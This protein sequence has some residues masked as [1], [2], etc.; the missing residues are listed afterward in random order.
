MEIDKLLTDFSD[1]NIYDFIEKNETPFYLFSEKIIQKQYQE[2]VRLFKTYWKGKWEIAY[3]LKNNPLPNIFQLT[4]KLGS[5]FEVTNINEMKLLRRY[6]ITGDLII[7]TNLIK[8]YSTL[9]YALNNDI[10]LFAI[11]SESDLERIE[12]IAKNLNKKVQV[13]LRINPL[14]EFDDI[15]FSCSGK[16]SKIG[17]PITLEEENLPN[18]RLGIIL[19]RITNSVFLK[20]KGIHMHL[21]SQITSEENYRLALIK[22][23]KLINLLNEKGI[24]PG[25]LDFGGGIPISYTNEDVPTAESLLKIAFSELKDIEDNIKLIIEPG[26][27]ISGPSGI[28]ISTIEIIK[29]NFLGNLILGLDF[30]FYNLLLDCIT[31]NWEFPVM[32]LQRNVNEEELLEYY[33]I[34]LTNDTLDTL[35]SD[36]KYTKF[37]LPK[38][39]EGEK[40]AFLQAGAYTIPFNNHYCLDSLPKIFWEDMNGKITLIRKTIQPKLLVDPDVRN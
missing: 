2:L 7:Y 10:S 40:I 28:L 5:Y 9:E 24:N 20:F 18:S 29:E 1:I 22:I 31:S 30:S 17:I 13:L 16:L 25:I 11:D 39:K 32:T 37:N 23:R 38:L 21:G 19:R 14:I 8:P 26:R 36:N 4:K 6:G 15:V 33:I 3:S 12:R 27:Y 34:G 35:V